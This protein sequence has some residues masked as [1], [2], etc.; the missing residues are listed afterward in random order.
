M[1]LL[2]KKNHVANGENADA[3][4]PMLDTESRE[5]IVYF[6][7]SVD[8]WSEAAYAAPRAVQAAPRRSWRPAAAWALGCALIASSVSGVAYRRHVERAR[9]NEAKAQLAAEQKQAADM[10][11]AREE[12][13]LASVDTDV[14][15]QVPSAMEPLAQM[16]EDDGR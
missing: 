11:A 14:A 12:D 10:Q 3:A 4:E 5:A 7:R 1:T 16:A 8:A 6:K 2:K 9:A 15:R 13:L